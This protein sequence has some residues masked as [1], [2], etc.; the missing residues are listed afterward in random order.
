MTAALVSKTLAAME[1]DGEKA[2][3][4]LRASDLCVAIFLPY[5]EFVLICLDSFCLPRRRKQCVHSEPVF[6]FLRAT[7]NET[8]VQAPPPKRRR[9]A[10]PTSSAQQPTQNLSGD[11]A[12]DALAAGVALA[13]HRPLADVDDDY[14]ADD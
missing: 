7:V 8:Q 3:T 12:A 1:K 13:G 9:G 4:T 11:G 2:S 14:D 10:G 6:D 5:H